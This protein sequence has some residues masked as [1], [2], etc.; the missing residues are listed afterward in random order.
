MIP[1]IWLINVM[2]INYWFMDGWPGW[3]LAE[4]K[5]AKEEEHESEDDAINMT[6]KFKSG[7]L[8]GLVCGIVIYFA[9]VYLLPAFGNA[10]TIFN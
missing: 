6:P 3:K 4:Y 7:L 2:L 10:L 9:I 8:I 5:K 1:M